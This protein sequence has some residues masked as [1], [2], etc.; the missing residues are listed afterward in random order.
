MT[1][2]ITRACASAS[3]A[4]GCPWTVLICSRQRSWISWSCL[5]EGGSSGVLCWK[6]RSVGWEPRVLGSRVSFKRTVHPCG[7]AYMTKLGGESWSNLE[8]LVELYSTSF[9]YWIKP[10]SSSSKSEEYSESESVEPPILEYVCFGWV[11]SGMPISTRR[12]FSFIQCSHDWVG[13]SPS[14]SLIQGL[15]KIDLP[16]CSRALDFPFWS[17]ACSQRASAF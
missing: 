16:D 2:S 10:S 9:L 17:L 13:V 8:F 4:L 7:V 5:H 15:S 1:Q 11:R 14:C 6:G 3:W 12:A